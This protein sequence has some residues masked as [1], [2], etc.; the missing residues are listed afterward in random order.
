MNRQEDLQLSLFDV[1]EEK[2]AEPSTPPD[3]D[4]WCLVYLV[5]RA[6]GNG[7]NLFVLHQE[8]AEKL[9]SDECSH[10]IGRGGPWMF[11]W[12]YLW[13]FYDSSDRSAADRQQRD[14]HGK[15]KP[16]KFIYDTG[17][18][19]EDFKRL[20]VK[21]PSIREIEKVLNSYGYQLEYERHKSPVER[22]VLTQEEFAAA[23][24]QVEETIKSGETRNWIKGVKK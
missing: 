15:L 10:G 3:T 14:T 2:S 5:T 19:D 8:D 24:K 18:Q 7:G 17:K 9:C 6:G 16:F 4:D 1:G 11:M 13:R 20:G 23:E 12:T 22:G 21:K